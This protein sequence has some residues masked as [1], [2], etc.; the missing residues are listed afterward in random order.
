MVPAL[1]KNQ[2]T[3]E[4]IFSITTSN[5]P[6]IVLIGNYSDYNIGDLAILDMIFEEFTKHCANAKITVVSRFPS[7][8][9]QFNPTIR[10]VKP[11]SLG[12]LKQIIACDFLLLGGGGFFGHEMGTFAQFVPIIALFCKTLNKKIVFYNVGIYSH[13]ASFI[14]FITNRALSVADII[15]LRSDSDISMVE[16]KILKRAALKPDLTFLLEPQPPSNVPKK[17]ERILK[18]KMVAI[19]LRKTNNST[20]KRVCK[21]IKKLVSWLLSKNINVVFVP[22]HSSDIEMAK[23]LSES[24][25]K[26]IILNTFKLNPHEIKWLFG[27]FDLVIG[28]RYHAI[29]FALSMNTPL[30]GLAYANKC[31]NL[32]KSKEIKV[33]EASNLEPDVFLDFAK[34]E[35]RRLVE[36]SKH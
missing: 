12:F 14:R 33:F 19:S 26:T 28:M 2:N 27:Q 4:R 20:D 32:L 29:V 24:K 13:V 18:Q 10:T 6:K 30:I 35:I 36:L 1:R 9:R 17:L 5:H 21:T 23:K 8:T 3:T 7:I 22:F 11:L 16:E 15:E 25:H 34:N 31:K